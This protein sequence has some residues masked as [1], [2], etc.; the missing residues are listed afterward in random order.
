MH[1]H[2]ARARATGTAPSGGRQGQVLGAVALG[3]AGPID[4]DGWG[5]EEDGVSA[6]ERVFYVVSLPCLRLLKAIQVKQGVL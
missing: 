5:F 1:R 4:L 3:T 2:R 6:P